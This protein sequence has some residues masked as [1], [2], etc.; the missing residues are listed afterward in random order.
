VN[1]DVLSFPP[2]EHAARTGPTLTQAFHSS[3]RRLVVQLYGVVGDISEAEDLVQEAFVRAT[4][5][6]KRFLRADNHEAWLRTTAIGL[7]RNRWRKVRNFARI[8]HRSE[9]PTDM[10]GLDEHHAGRMAQRQVMSA[11]QWHAISVV[12]PR[13]PGRS[14]QRRRSLHARRIVSRFSAP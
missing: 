3:Y 4:A 14:W 13:R 11:A 8:R 1:E 5:A 12:R 10:Q 2:R 6:G 7:H 9:R